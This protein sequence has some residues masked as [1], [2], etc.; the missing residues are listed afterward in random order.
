MLKEEHFTGH[1]IRTFKS[2]I[3]KNNNLIKKK[4]RNIEIIEDFMVCE[5]Q[6]L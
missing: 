4:T 1:T 3:K 5:Q 6:R 2:L